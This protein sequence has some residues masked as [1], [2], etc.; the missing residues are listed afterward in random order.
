MPER[1]RRPLVMGFIKVPWVYSLVNA[2]S[3]IS[4]LVAVGGTISL[5][6]YSREISPTVAVGLGLSVMA[7]VFNILCDVVAE[8]A[9]E[10]PLVILMN[11]ESFSLRKLQWAV[12]MA[13]HP[14]AQNFFLNRFSEENLDRLIFEAQVLLNQQVP[15]V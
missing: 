12:R 7:F 6:V 1:L 10:A 3:K 11:P 13:S 2:I 15:A 8:I 4:L 5:A 14:G 9:C